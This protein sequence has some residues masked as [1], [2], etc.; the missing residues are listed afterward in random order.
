[1]RK[2]FYLNSNDPLFDLLRDMRH[3]P[4]P[5]G[6]D[7]PGRVQVKE[8]AYSGGG[9]HSRF[10]GRGGDLGMGMGAW[11]VQNSSPLGRAPVSD[12]EFVVFGVGIIER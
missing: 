9:Y 7:V 2:P 12:G 6:G 3:S 11:P 8:G 10:T 5:C 1:M 4:C